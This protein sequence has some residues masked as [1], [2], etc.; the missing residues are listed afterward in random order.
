MQVCR[1]T[2]VEE[3]LD[4]PLPLSDPSALLRVAELAS[5]PAGDVRAIARECA[6]DEALSALV[7]RL[8]NSA[9]QGRGFRV[10]ELPTAIT[11]LGLRLVATL[12]ITAPALRLLE[13]CPRDDLTPA[14]RALHEHAVKTGITARLLALPDVEP[15]AALAAGLLHNLGLTLVSLH[16]VDAFR[17]LVELAGRGE[18]LALYEPELLGTTH[19]ELG[20][21]LAARWS[22]PPLLVD[23]IREHDL[24]EPTTRMAQVVRAADLMT[25]MSGQG[26][27]PVEPMTPELLAPAGGES[28]TSGDWMLAATALR[29]RDLAECLLDV[30]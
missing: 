2:R 23:A 7:L 14:R 1:P 20:A 22:Y 29:S 9:S 3:I 15:E 19:A 5:D 26:I 12:A 30:A 13:A 28:D 10:A 4:R 27:E 16:D 11:R 24:A 6:R 8:A 21:E 18:R 17:K 25:R